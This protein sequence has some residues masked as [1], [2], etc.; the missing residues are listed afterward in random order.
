[1]TTPFAT[2]GIDDLQARPLGEGYGY[3]VTF[4][5][6]HEGLCHQLYV[7]GRLAD[8]T[9]D[10]SGR[11][12]FVAEPEGPHNVAVVAVEYESRQTD[13]SA[14]AGDVLA[15]P[16]WVFR[17]SVARG[18]WTGRGDRVA[19]LG[20]HATGTIN[21]EPLAVRDVWPEWVGHQG[22]GQDGFGLSAFGYDSSAAPGFA[23][24]AFGAG[25]FGLDGDLITLEA[26][27]EEEGLHRLVVRRTQ[28]DG[29][30]ADGPETVFLCTPPP[31]PPEWLQAASYDAQSGLL[32]LQLQ[33]G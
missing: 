28:P 11:G 21:P 13:F 4:R 32:T 20:D 2:Q 30:F 22:W 5:S 23:R 14:M 18:T 19:L 10:P 12:F 1:M 9:E 26:G 29:S 7:D 27:L 8:W 6:T 33:R 17:T 3:E 24:G 16:A 15:P 25:P 31:A